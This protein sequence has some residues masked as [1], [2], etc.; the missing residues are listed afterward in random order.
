MYKLISLILLNKNW[1]LNINFSNNLH[2]EQNRC[3]D[4]LL[5]PFP[6]Y[7][8]LP[9]NLHKSYLT[10]YKTFGWSD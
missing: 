1:K 8:L 9:D 7:D 3:L 2:I 4:Y 5:A 6:P 10:I